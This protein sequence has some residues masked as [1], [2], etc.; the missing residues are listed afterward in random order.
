[1]TQN[2]KYFSLHSAK[3]AGNDY[4]NA[5]CSLISFQKTIF[6]PISSSAPWSSQPT[7]PPQPHLYSPY[8][9]PLSSPTTLKHHCTFPLIYINISKNQSPPKNLRLFSTKDQDSIRIK[10]LK[11]FQDFSISEI[12]LI[13]LSCKSCKSWSRRC[14]DGFKGSED[15]QSVTICKG[16][17]TD[18]CRCKP[19]GILL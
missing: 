14:D 16:F 15:F 10:G 7:P 19:V 11:D 17:I 6:P 5:T 3:I 2:H 18:W 4:I 13:L 8:P 9:S 12:S 1:M